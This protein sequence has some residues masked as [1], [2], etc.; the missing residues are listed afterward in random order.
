MATIAL[1]SNDAVEA[2]AHIEV[3]LQR[4]PDHGPTWLLAGQIAQS[5][6]DLGL[7]VQRLDRAAALDPK[8]EDAA[9]ARGRASIELAGRVPSNTPGRPD[10]AGL[11]AD[12]E[13]RFPHFAPGWIAVS[14]DLERIGQFKPALAAAA[15]AA[16]AA[17][18]VAAFLK[19]AQ[20]ALQLAQP[21]LAADA[22]QRALALDPNLPPVWFK[23]GV[24]LQDSKRRDAAIHA[25]QRALALKPDMAEAAVNLGILLQDSGDIDA[26]KR[27]Y[28]TALRERADTFGR[29]AQALTAAPKGELWLDLGALRSHLSTLGV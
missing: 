11:I 27:A 14:A 24:I 15:R 9:F 19:C 18:S 28:G 21:Q 4:R 29:I 3:S 8:R 5:R 7:A 1:R 6:G 2:E 10:L 22:L 16:N 25:Y 13:R 17:P 12:L 20:L 23:L 26:A